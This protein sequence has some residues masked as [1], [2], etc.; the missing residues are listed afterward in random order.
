MDFG[1]TWTESAISDLRG[2]VRYIARDNRAAAERLGLLMISKVD[3]LG[4]FPRIGH[5]VPEFALES[6]RQ[7]SVAPYR[8]VH[9][10]NDGD[11]TVSV[12]RVWHGARDRLDE[13]SLKPGV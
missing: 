5:R 9:E 1:I 11:S 3:S 8:I 13:S 12:L 2:I 7:I 4:K 10:I 6:I